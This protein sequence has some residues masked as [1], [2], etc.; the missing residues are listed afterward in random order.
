MTET[1]E[2]STESGAGAED[3]SGVLGGIRSVSK[4]AG[5]FAVG[6]FSTNVFGLL[7]NLVLTR[8][9]GAESYGLYA[10]AGTVTSVPATFTQFGART[11]LSRL[12]PE[13][14]DSRR[15]DEL[16]GLNLFAA[17]VASSVA[18][19][20]LVAVAPQFSRFVFGDTDLVPVLRLLALSMPFTGMLSVSMA[21]FKATERLEYPV[22]IRDVIQPALWLSL[23]VAVSFLSATLLAVVVARLGLTVFVGLLSLAAVLLRTGRSF[24]L[25][26]DRGTVIEFFRYSLPL[27]ARD[28][29]SIMYNRA[30]LFIVGFLLTESSVGIYRIAFLV[31]GIAAIP[32]YGFNQLFPPLASRLHSDDRRDDLQAVYST[33]TRW[34]LTLSLV[35]TIGGVVYATEILRLFGPEFAAGVGVLVVIMVSEMLNA[36]VG[37]SGLVLIM[38][39]HQKFATANQWAFGLLNVGLNVVLVLE[40]GLVGAAVATASTT[41]VQ[42]AVR[43]YFVRRFEGYMPYDV[44]FLKPL[45]AGAVSAGLMI[46][47]SFLLDGLVLLFV[48]G[49][50]GTL[51]YFGVL[52]LLGPEDIDEE[53][54]VELVGRLR[55]M[56]E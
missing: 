50:A 45:A 35:L 31:A 18:A 7:V 33:V 36:A 30:D 26:T 17:V 51:A 46:G 56:A 6:R 27:T 10:Y 12:V 38:T 15:T 3:D 9:L 52:Y 11:V 16:V 34:S 25:P 54:V 41:V 44:T 2:T 5:L 53:F 8:M 13:H 47:A 22:L 49:A 23:V 43:L 42:N 55:A 39:D 20:V 24:A 32:L 4:G 1:G 37:P 14:G 48:G 28:V 21:V 19:G 29:G 40:F